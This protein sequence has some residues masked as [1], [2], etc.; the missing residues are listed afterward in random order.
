MFMQAYEDM[1]LS[2]AV[3]EEKKQ[4]RH[5]SMILMSDRSESSENTFS[6]DVQSARS[7]SPIK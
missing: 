7:A 4:Q 1:I 2:V 6:R 5:Q 3:E